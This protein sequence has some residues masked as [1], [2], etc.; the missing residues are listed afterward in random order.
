MREVTFFSL[1]CVWPSGEA[2]R[3]SQGHSGLDGKTPG[4][5][6]RAQVH[7]CRQLKALQKAI[8]LSVI[9]ASVPW[10]TLQNSPLI[11]RHHRGTL[12]PRCLLPVHPTSSLFT[13]LHEDICSPSVAA[14]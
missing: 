8:G 9:L 14:I 13:P 4:L 5:E 1:A 2:R 10:T 6:A 7:H 3:G 11:H 12:A